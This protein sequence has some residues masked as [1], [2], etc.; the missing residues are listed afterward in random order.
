[1]SVKQ[2]T[3]KEQQLVGRAFRCSDGLIRWITHLSTRRYYSLLWLNEAEGV[4]YSG[5]IVK[6]NQWEGGEEV[7]APQPGQPY[8]IAGATGV[9][10]TF[11]PLAEGEISS[12]RS[13][14]LDGSCNRLELL[15]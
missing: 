11:T 9:I 4:W 13:D 14:S 3:S 12:D 7:P 5:G 2:E 15:R 6:A 8:R 1:M 10:R